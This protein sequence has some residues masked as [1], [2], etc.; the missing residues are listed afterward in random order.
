MSFKFAI[1]CHLICHFNSI[2]QP[3]SNV[4]LS[5]TSLLFVSRHSIPITQ[6]NCYSVP[7][8]THT[9]SHFNLS[10]KSMRSCSV[11]HNFPLQLFTPHHFYQH[12]LR[13]TLP[14]NFSHNHKLFFPRRFLHSTPLTTQTKTLPPSHKLS[15]H[16]QQI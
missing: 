6:C 8:L 3:F 13:F 14:H 7:K 11:L 10:T 12:T 16:L 9:T 2:F 4:M 15:S 5:T 1:L